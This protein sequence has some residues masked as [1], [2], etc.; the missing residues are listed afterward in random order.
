MKLNHNT[1]LFIDFDPVPTPIQYALKALKRDWQRIFDAELQQINA[2]QPNQIRI[3]EGTQAHDEGFYVMINDE[4]LHIQAQDDLGV[5][6]GIYHICET[7]LNVD[8]LEFWTDYQ[9]QPTDTIEVP[10]SKYQSPEPQVRFRGWF[11]NDED[12]LMGWHDNMEISLATWERIYES[13]LRSGYNT[14]IPGTTVDPDDSP[15]QLA[16]DMGLWL[17]HHHAQPL[18]ARLFRTVHP[19]VTPR[20]PEHLP[21]FEK[22]YLEAIDKLKDKKVVW[23]LGFRGQGDLPFFVGDPRYPTPGQQGKLISDMIQLQRQLI[24]A[25]VPEPHYF[26]HQVYSESAALYKD[27][28]L[29]LDDDV[30]RVW[31]DNGYGAMRARREWGPDPEIQSY[32]LPSDT[33]KQSGVYYHVQF[34]DLQ[35][36]HRITPF[37]DPHL[38]VDE[39]QKI[40]DA[41]NIA[42]VVVNTGNIRPHVFNL[43]LLSRILRNNDA[44]STQEIFAKHEKT[45]ASRY[46]RGSAQNILDLLYRYHQA[47]FRYGDHAD[48]TGGEELC[49]W[50]TR[51]AIRAVV[52]HQ[53]IFDTHFS[54]PFLKGQV[55]TNREAFTW[56]IER[57]EAIL[58]EWNAI[59]QRSV[60]I[61]S[62]LPDQ[63]RTYYNTLMKRHIQ[64]MH[65]SYAGFL[66]ALYGSLAY[67]DEDYQSAFI[68][69]SDSKVHMET[70]WEGITSD[71]NPKWQNF[72]RGEWLTG[73][74]ES[75]R[76][77]Q[78]AQGLCRIHGDSEQWWSGWMLEAMGQEKHVML[79]TINQSL[80]DYDRL[81]QALKMRRE[82]DLMPLN[83]LL[84]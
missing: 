12:C 77:L 66:S 27:G 31:A 17:T 55:T 33:D 51:F 56:L 34:H 50:G 18:G 79:A 1:T 70:A 76:W 38:I 73:V 21:L 29:S 58:P 28:H 19:G 11:I 72:Y 45:W 47:F 37:V 9:Y 59:E 30:I 74:R 69:F 4:S 57:L 75:I 67:M 62:T 36:A 6:Y 82:G 41:G 13:L 23:S 46:F 80:T 40:Y 26:A 49:Q 78:T 20:I 65:Y 22:L 24:E 61:E 25:H 48:D 14:V 60:E 15:I 63:Q 54:F 43:E 35:A 42:L 52:R 68:H 83:A 2:T 7:I 64:Y 84:G 39:F 16:A 5:V 81:A 3:T 8:P 44:E 32:P 53:S 10:A 71:D